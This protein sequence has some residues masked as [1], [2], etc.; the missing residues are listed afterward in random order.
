MSFFVFL[1]VNS[2]PYYQDKKSLK[3]KPQNQGQKQGKDRLP[4][5]SIPRGSLAGW[6]VSPWEHGKTKREGLGGFPDR[7]LLYS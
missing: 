5:P 2:Y 6:Q 1:C 7:Q 3:T 4:N